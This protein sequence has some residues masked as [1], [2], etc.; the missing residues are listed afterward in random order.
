MQQQSIID[1]IIDVNDPMQAMKTVFAL[2]SNDFKR[3]YSTPPNNNQRISSN[4]SYKQ[5]T[6][7]GM[8]TN[9]GRSM[10]MVA[11]TL[12]NT[13]TALVYDTYGLSKVPNFD[14]Y[15]INEIYNLFAHEEQHSELPKSTK[16][17]HVEQKCDSNIMAENLD[18][19]FSEEDV[20]QHAVNNEET[21]AYFE[22]ILN[23]FKNELDSCVMVNHKAK[24]A[25]EILSLHSTRDNKRTSEKIIKSLNVEILELKNPL[26]KQETAYSTLEKDKVKNDIDDIETINIELIHNVATL[27]KENEDLKQ[28]YKKLYDS[29][30]KTRAQTKDQTNSLIPQLNSKTIENADLIGQLQDKTFAYAELQKIIKGK[31]I[32]TN[33]SKPS[34]LI[35]PPSSKP[36]ITS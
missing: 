29:L 7:P 22:A 14:N 9:E 30:K 17:T 1:T 24:A 19:N 3:Q 35:K 23:N 18:M 21:N 4:T 32:N 27:L 16:G 25:N 10:Q 13:S 11:P 12:L 5:I 20:D 6:Q 34:I 15:H 28:T 2:K 31:N 26:L 33:F 36:L 8:N